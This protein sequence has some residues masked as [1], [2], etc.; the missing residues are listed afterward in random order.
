MMA[1][2]M[3]VG[4]GLVMLGFI[5]GLKYKDSCSIEAPIESI[6]FPT[7][8]EGKYYSTKTAMREA[9]ERGEDR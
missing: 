4:A 9:M 6:D 3:L 1:L 5:L 7:I 2:G 8:G